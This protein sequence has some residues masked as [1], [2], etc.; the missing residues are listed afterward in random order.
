MPIYTSRRRSRYYPSRSYRSYRSFNRGRSRTKRRALGNYRAALSQKD[1]TDVNLSIPSS[2][3]VF[4]Q[5]TALSKTVD[6]NSTVYWIDTGTY[7]LNIWDLLRKSEF[8]QSY[9]NMY[10]QVKINSVKIKLTPKSYTISNSNSYKAFT[11][12]TAWDR[13]GLSNEQITLQHQVINSDNEIGLLGNKDGIYVSVS[14]DDVATYSSAVSKSLNPNTNTSIVRYL[15][16]S[17]MAEKSAYVNTADLDDW[18]KG[19]EDTTGRYY[20]LKNPNGV[21]AN[22]V[23]NNNIYF[24]TA[25]LETVNSNLRDTNPAYLVE[26]PSFP[27]KPTLLIASMDATP[28]NDPSTNLYPRETALLTFNIEADIGVTFRGLR[29]ASIVL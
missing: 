2:C 11:I 9:S 23:N 10:D 25:P 18:Y 8:Y 15:Y 19:Y 16:P 27:F 28:R 1:S 14:A 5:Q 4:N 3:T 24:A 20:G 17:S 29:K 13:T 6:G 22:W 12:C 7:A 21:A 26:S